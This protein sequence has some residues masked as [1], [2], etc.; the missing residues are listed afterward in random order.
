MLKKNELDA[1]EERYSRII[2]HCVRERRMSLSW[3]QQRL[4]DASG[5]SRAEIQFVER[6][7]RRAKIGTV[8][9]LCAALGVSY[10]ELAA[11]AERVDREWEKLGQ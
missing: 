9:R 1:L 8:R 6:G 4:A 7:R 11:Q 10:L 2:G 5:L 3:S